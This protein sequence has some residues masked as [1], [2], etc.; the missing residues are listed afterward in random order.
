LSDA[1]PPRRRALRVAGWVLGLAGVCGAIVVSRATLTAHAELKAGEAAL[2]RGDVDL[3]IDALERA[4]RMRVPGARTHLTALDR[5]EAVGGS[6]ATAGDVRTA[7]AAYEAVRRAILGTRSLG[8][9]EGARLQRIDGRLAELLARADTGDTPELRRAWHAARL[10]QAPAPR[11][12][13]TVLLLIGFGLWVGGGA[14]LA[15][16]GFGP[17]DKLRRWQA[18]VAAAA[19]VVGLV[20]WLV[21]L[22]R[23]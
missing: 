23:A 13:F 9:P 22:W 11:P 17:D 21:G 10:A 8:T 5:L 14:A 12:G 19:I 18:L 6:A 1:V 15:L 16:G 7:R 2:A 3:A 4:G 20:L